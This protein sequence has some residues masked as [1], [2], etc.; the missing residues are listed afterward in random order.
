[1]KLTALS[2]LLLIACAF[3]QT[4]F[5]S[6]FTKQTEQAGLPGFI[7]D[8]RV[9][10][11]SAIMTSIILVAI[12]Y[13]VGIGME[14]PEIRAWAGSE[15]VQIFVTAI[16]IITFM[17]VLGLLD[18]IA[19]ETAQYSGISMACSGGQ[20]CLQSIAETYLGTYIDVA[21]EDARKIALDSIDAGS[22]ASRRFG[23]YC[24][25]IYCLQ[26]GATFG[27]NG[28][29]VLDTDRYN[30]VFEYYSGILSSMEAQR[31]FISHIS[32]SIGP[33][34]LAMGIV[35]RSFF[36]TR[37][38]G[39][40]LIAV[41]A[42]IMF[43]L[44]GMYLFDWFTL[45]TTL[46][47]NK[48]NEDM[49][50]SLCPDECKI[51]H[52]LAYVEN[53]SQTIPLGSVKAVYDV[54]PDSQSADAQAIIAGTANTAIPAEG[55]YKDMTVA[56]CMIVSDADC[57]ISCRELPYPTSLTT[58]MD[59]DAM[60]QQ[61]CA[62]L[63]PDKCWLR[64]FA[65][66][67][68][69]EETPS[70]VSCPLECRVVPPMK[71]DCF[72]DMGDCLESRPECRLFKKTGDTG[73][74]ETDFAWAPNPNRD[75][76]E[77]QYD[78]CEQAKDCIPSLNALESCAYVIPET[79][80]CLGLCEGCP[81]VC[82]VFTT[83]IGKLPAQCIDSDTNDL[84]ASCKACPAGCKVNATYIDEAEAKRVA[85]GGEAKCAGC[86][87]EKRI[88]A[89]GE[90]MPED[91]VT[92]ACDISTSCP[93]DDRVA[94]PRTSCEQCIFTEESQ[95]YDP[96]IQPDCTALCR[97]SDDLPTK[98][99]SAYTAIGGEGLVGSTDI[100]NVS[101]LMLPGYVLPLFNIVSTLVF[102]RGLSVALG[103]DIEIPGISKVF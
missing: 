103:G 75:A 3:A 68:P 8:W 40:L 97:P 95:I 12:A 36:F 39:G 11:I 62:A 16:I 31:F 100:Q 91:Y 79:G 44:P 32:F 2:L 96:P 64:R 22:W 78:R 54:F 1:M 51:P 4:E 21:K 42:G 19:V 6:N 43:I 76:S 85:A 23:L 34:I 33:L 26:I 58:C 90:A 18:A 80:Q 50:G 56:S 63:L 17:V 60:I 27:V 37:K 72:T 10:A 15:L 81:Q 66:A 69:A 7:R 53:G 13:A 84:T 73:D 30:I 92:G 82:R 5:E 74:A 38:L 93:S 61:K 47:G 9:I 67:P 35:G 94:I 45:D 87:S 101:K 59:P 29:Y 28:H 55:P 48:A 57:P 77:D 83:D 86:A 46:T 41:S 52:S 14:I 71:G 88:I 70:L 102:I 89:Y 20:S 98:S 49:G 65:G 25:S 99:P 24:T